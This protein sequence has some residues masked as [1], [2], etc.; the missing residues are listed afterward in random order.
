MMFQNHKT[1]VGDT[2]SQNDSQNASHAK[3]DSPHQSDSKP[4]D[5]LSRVSLNPQ[6]IAPQHQNIQTG[7]SPNGVDSPVSSFHFPPNMPNNALEQQNMQQQDSPKDAQLSPP[8]NISASEND[9]NDTEVQVQNN[10]VFDGVRRSTRERTNASHTD[11][12]YFRTVE[13]EKEKHINYF[14]QLE[15]QR[16]ANSACLSNSQHANYD[17]CLQAENTHLAFEEAQH[18]DMLLSANLEKLW[19]LSTALWHHSVKSQTLHT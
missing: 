10:P 5:A 9:S 6:N 15:L 2:N 4:Q 7:Q 19:T 1:V 3:D 18:Q 8:Q 14:Q 13:K 12:E 16:Q 17:T 11:A